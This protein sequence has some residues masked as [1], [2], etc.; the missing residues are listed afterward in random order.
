MHESI[1]AKEIC[2]SAQPEVYRKRPE[3]LFIELSFGN[4]RMLCGV[5]YSP[6]HCGHWADVEEALLNC[7]NAYDFTLIMGDFNIDWHATSTPRKIL[8]DSLASCLL[9]PL[10]FNTTN[11]EVKKDVESNTTIDYICVSDRSKVISFNQTSIP[12]ISNHD[13]LF[14]VLDFIAPVYSYPY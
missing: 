14:A 12:N 6:P 7:N 11:H 9:E 5:I 1:T 3:F 13:V 4:L 10:P 8:S 2:R